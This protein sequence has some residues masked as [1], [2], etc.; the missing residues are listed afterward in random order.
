MTFEKIYT[1]HYDLLLRCAK[2]RLQLNH[3][4]AEDV[5]AETFTNLYKFMQKGGIIEHPHA[6][7]YTALRRAYTDH[8]RSCWKHKIATGT[9]IKQIGVLHR[10][11][12]LVDAKDAIMGLITPLKPSERQAL[13]LIYVDQLDSVTAAQ[14]IGITVK[15]LEQRTYRARRKL[16]TLLS[17]KEQCNA[18]ER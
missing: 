5:V 17:L 10:D 3:N 6:W 14:Q 9:W 4:D 15:N 11:F 12:E 18:Q 2:S 16:H 13:K 1:D 8:V 7:L